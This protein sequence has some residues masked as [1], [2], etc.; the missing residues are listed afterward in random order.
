MKSSIE[1]LASTHPDLEVWWDSSPLVYEQWVQKMLDSAEPGH[2]PLL[3]D[4]ILRPEIDEPVPQAVLDKL[5]QIPYCIQAWDPN[6]LALEQFNDHPATLYTVD[7]FSRVSGPE[8]V[9]RETG[10]VG[11]KV[12][13]KL[14]RRHPPLMRQPLRVTPPNGGRTELP[15]LWGGLRGGNY[16]RS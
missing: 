16:L 10:G 8:R 11:E 9:R 2:R 3:D 14:L 15:P 13:T 4:L 7:A 12:R 1:R 6:G 5:A